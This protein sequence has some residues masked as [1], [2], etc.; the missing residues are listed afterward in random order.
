MVQRSCP[1]L[2]QLVPWQV[3]RAGLL[4]LQ[5]RKQA[6]LVGGA[7]RD[8]MLGRRPQDWDIA[9][10]SLPETTMAVFR[11]AG[12]QV[13]PTGLRFG[14]ITVVIGS[15]PIEITTLRT[16]DGYSDARHPDRVNFVPDVA[17]D[18][19]RRDFTINAIALDLRTGQLV[20]PVAGVRDLR[21]GRIR[22]V[23]R[24]GERFAEDPLRMLRAARLVGQLAFTVEAET[25]RQMASCGHLLSLV[26]AERIWNEIEKLLGGREA[27]AGLRVLVDTGL[28]FVIFPE[29]WAGFGFPQTG[30]PHIYTVLEHQLETVRYVPADPELRLAALLHDVAK[31][32][33]YSRGEDGRAHFYGHDREGAKMAVRIS[34]RLRAPRTTAER[35]AALV[36]WH[37][38]PLGLG[39]RGL[40]R[41]MSRVGTEN[42]L[43]LLALKQAD[44]VA[45]GP[46][47]LAA[48][49]EQLRCLQEQVAGIMG[50]G[51]AI[52]LKDLAVGGR[53]VMAV[54]GWPPGPPVGKILYLLLEEVWEDP[55]KN[56]REY[57][58]E[59]IADLGAQA[60]GEAGGENRRQGHHGPRERVSPDLNRMKTRVRG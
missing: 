9:T 2:A 16:E 12:Y 57:L 50:A 1:G 36:S 17:L 5:Q 26:A 51:Q 40:R 45:T 43:D 23:G 15:L 4:L 31:P 59:R 54:L 39:P 44:L 20:D 56:T 22:A 52:T 34:R 49:L 7:L 10:S 21:Q 58:L 18:L 30:S 19:A 37:M 55:E 53:E 48:R 46:G 42:I 3:R 29:L 38:F 60:G 13:H 41:L 33:C 32:I 28:L 27:M 11:Q 14:T 47:V 35:V 6:F 25:E 24:A 8:I